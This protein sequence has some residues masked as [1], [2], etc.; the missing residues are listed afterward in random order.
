MEIQI[1]AGGINI[2]KHGDVLRSELDI[3]SP[4]VCLKQIKTKINKY[5][6]TLNC[7]ISLFPV[8]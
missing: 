1:H 8:Q 5:K 3:Q 4:G 6:F 7:T 2:V